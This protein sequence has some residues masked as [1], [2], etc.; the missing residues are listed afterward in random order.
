MILIALNI[1]F[2]EYNKTAAIVF[3]IIALIFL[4]F[5]TKIIIKIE[6]DKIQII[7]KR[8][9]KAL[10]SEEVYSKMDIE[11][12]QY[13]PSKIH[14]LILLLPGVGGLENSKLTIKT[15]S[16]DKKEYNIS[17]KEKDIKILNDYT[18]QIND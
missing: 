10:S 17:L 16:G 7:K 11:I 18:K 1:L 2:Y 15:T 13:E 9:F 3:G 5:S 8:L 4:L 6:T 12:I 14:F